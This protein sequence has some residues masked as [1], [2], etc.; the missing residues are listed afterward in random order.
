M[1]TR[2][3]LTA[4]A[5]GTVAALAGCTDV[6]SD[7]G[8]QTEILEA[9]EQHQDGLDS[10][11]SGFSAWNRDDYA[12][13][14]SRFEEAASTFGSADEMIAVMITAETNVPIEFTRAVQMPLEASMA[15]SQC[16]DGIEAVR[17]ND[18]LSRRDGETI[19]QKRQRFESGDYDMPTLSEA[20]DMF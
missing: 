1:P 16:V 8:E 10:F 14:Q 9:Y 13:A 15:A 11:R 18:D 17:D 2:R 5:A 12:V 20:E 6:F 7:N 19:E 3:L 4:T